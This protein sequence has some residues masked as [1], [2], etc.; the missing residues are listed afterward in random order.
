MEDLITHANVLFQQSGTG[1][2]PLPPAPLHESAAHVAY[3]STHTKLTSMPPPPVPTSPRKTHQKVPSVSGTPRSSFDLP[4]PG[5][6]ELTPQ[7]PPRPTPQDFT[8]SLPPRPTNSIHPSLRAGPHASSPARQGPSL[9]AGQF[10]DDQVRVT[11]QSSL[12]PT[13][14]GSVNTSTSSLATPP[15]LKDLKE[16]PPLFTS[17]SGTT[18]ASTRAT[19]PPPQPTQPHS[20]AAS[21][22]STSSP[23]ADAP[24]PFNPAASVSPDAFPVQQP[25]PPQTHRT[26]S[27]ESGM[28]LS[29][30][31]T[32]AAFASASPS[33]PSSAS[34]HSSPSKRSAHGR[35]QS[36]SD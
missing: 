31:A 7:L 2:P 17:P 19:S 36:T 13:Y 15:S 9:R 1:S 25:A 16:E 32:A 20:R 35:K 8:P 24:D 4:R 28:E 11:P 22:R 14:E 29:S 3:G 21:T 23:I 26:G 30:T 5:M 18:M 33:P 10:F 12:S 27:H 6:Q 34:G